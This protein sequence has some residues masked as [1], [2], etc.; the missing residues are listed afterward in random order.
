VAESDGEGAAL[1]LAAGVGV[2]L[3]VGFAAVPQPTINVNDMVRARISARVLFINILLKI[4]MI[5]NTLQMK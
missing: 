4:K 2:A 1:L 5:L 3:A